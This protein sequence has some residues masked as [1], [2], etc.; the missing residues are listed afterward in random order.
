MS[1][2]LCFNAN[3]I[4]QEHIHL[5]NLLRSTID[6]LAKEYHTRIEGLSA[7]QSVQEQMHLI[8]LL[9]HTVNKLTKEYN[10]QMKELLAYQKSF[11]GST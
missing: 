4:I 2:K 8:N 11:K 5:T 9:E 6:E 10:K 7:Y 3:K 1:K